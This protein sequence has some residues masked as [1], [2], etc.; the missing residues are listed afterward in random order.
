MSDKPKFDS[1]IPYHLMDKWA[2]NWT[3]FIKGI[4]VVLISSAVGVL[5]LFQS[6]NASKL[7]E[8]NGE[9]IVSLTESNTRLV[10]ENKDLRYQIAN[11]Q[12]ELTLVQNQMLLKNKQIENLKMQEKQLL[13]RIE[14]LEKQLK[15]S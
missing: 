13:A 3:S 1:E 5:A 14:E 6:H 8:K 2:V 9:I 15:K 7:A 12:R 4:L 11:H 10:E